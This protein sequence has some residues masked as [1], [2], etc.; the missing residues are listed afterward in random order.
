MLEQMIAEQSA[1]LYMQLLERAVKDKYR[2]HRDYHLMIQSIRSDLPIIGGEIKVQKEDGNGNFY[3]ETYHV[4]VLDDLG[5]PLHGVD[6]LGG[7]CRKGEIVKKGFLFTCMKCGKN[8]CREHIEFVDDD[9]RKP[10]C[11]YDRGWFMS[12]GCYWAYKQKYSVTKIDEKNLN[13]TSTANLRE[14]LE[15]EKI[16][17]EIKELKGD[18]VSNESHPQLESPSRKSLPPPKKKRGFLA[19][20][21][22][23]ISSINC[24]NPYCDKVI[25]LHDLICPGCRNTITIR[26]GDAFVCPHCTEPVKQVECTTCGSTNEL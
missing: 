12:Q 14:Y 9:S 26:N 25:P 24:G 23:D 17:K 18:E 2:G 3:T 1:Q 15:R 20:L 7:Q 11:S 22:S 21:F 8:F 4:T 19:R 6:D 10:L 13:K 5:N 16:L